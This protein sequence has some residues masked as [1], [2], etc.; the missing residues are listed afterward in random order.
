MVSLLG[1][2]A[3][4]VC[5]PLTSTPSDY[6][7]TSKDSTKSPNAL[8]SNASVTPWNGGSVHGNSD[9]ACTCQVFFFLTPRTCHSGDA[10]LGTDLRTSAIRS[11]KRTTRL[12]MS[13]ILPIR[14]TLSILLS[15]SRRQLF[16]QAPEA[17]VNDLER[18]ELSHSYQLYASSLT[19]TAGSTATAQLTTSTTQSLARCKR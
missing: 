18:G 12:E 19:L 5:P 17:G 8:T 14:T 6:G 9:G 13:Q 11:N 10:E 16:V 2:K 7:Y 4:R 15:T 1:L 3:P